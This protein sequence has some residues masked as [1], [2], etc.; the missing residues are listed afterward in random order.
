MRVRVL[1]SVPAPCKQ[2]LQQVTPEG[3]GLGDPPGISSTAQ[4][5]DWVQ[6]RATKITRGLEHLAY[7]ERLRVGLFSLDKRRV[8]GNII[9]AFQYLKGTYKRGT[10]FLAGPVSIGKGV[11]VLN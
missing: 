5:G 8:W 7:R 4:S 6:R 10:D 11:I 1:S 3:L 2:E 9:A